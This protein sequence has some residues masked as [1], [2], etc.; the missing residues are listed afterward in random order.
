MPEEVPSKI[1]EKVLQVTAQ[2]KADGIETRPFFVA[3]LSKVEDLLNDWKRELP[4]VTPYYGK[5]AIVPLFQTTCL[6]STQ[7]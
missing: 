2:Q 5:H 1:T 4:L 3:D 6:P 7:P